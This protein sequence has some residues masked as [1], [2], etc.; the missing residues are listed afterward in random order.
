L[1]R[2]GPFPS[3]SVEDNLADFRAAIAANQRGAAGLL[4]LARE[5][6]SERFAAH[7]RAIMQRAERL[8]RETLAALNGRHFAAIECLDDGS[9]IQVAIEVARGEATIDF[10]GTAGVH[11]GNL[12]ATPAIVRSA[13]MYVLRLLIG[14]RLPLNEGMMKAVRI[15]IPEGMLN[16]SFADNPSNSPAVVGGNTETSQRVVDTL[17]KA[18]DGRLGACSQ[19]T[20]NNVLFGNSRMGYYETVCG[21][22][23]GAEG[24]AGPDAVHSHMT[25]TRIT[26]V[27]IIE[28]RYPV[29]VERFTI[30]QGSGGAGQYPGGCGV[31]RELKFLEPMSLSVVSQHR[32]QG[33]FGLRGGEAGA[34]GRQTLVRANGETRK[35]SSLDAVEMWPGDRFLLETPG[36][37]GFEK[38]SDE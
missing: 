30:R 11:P 18:L 3:R 34:P 12:N 8:A 29:Q 1:L 31:V 17:I 26:D 13:V 28:R 22:C 15:Q 25:N 24:F 37:G 27:E 32:V 16:P 23:G 38:P 35:L 5:H 7:M 6:G 10:A 4:S 9:P 2:G 33:P 21:G 14:Q 36:G 20:M 19:G